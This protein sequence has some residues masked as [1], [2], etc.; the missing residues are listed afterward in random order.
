MY[1]S[2]MK[3]IILSIVCA[4]FYNLLCAQDASLDQIIKQVTGTFRDSLSKYDY[5]QKIILPDEDGKNCVLFNISKSTSFSRVNMLLDPKAKDE[6]L[7]I[8]PKPFKQAATADGFEELTMPQ[9]GFTSIMRQNIEEN[10]SHNG[11]TVIYK[12]KA[13]RNS[14]GHYGLFMRPGNYNLF[15]YAWIFPE[16][17]KP[18]SYSSNRKGHWLTKNNMINFVADTGQNDFLFDIRYVKAFNIPSTLEGRRIDFI[19]TLTIHSDTIQVLLNDPEVEDG[20]IISLNVNG[21]WKLRN[22]YLTNAPAKFTFVMLRGEN[23]IAMHAENLGSIPPNTGQLTIIDG[24]TKKQIILNSDAGKT[25]GI[26][27][28]RE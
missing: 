26:L 22:F 8:F 5:V 15:S 13:T 21:E 11:D 10:L 28:K 3:K 20:D 7:Y 18:V 12:T 1:I 19:Q 27:L 17:L 25:Q 4:A 6:M 16:G 2:Y 14:D 24:T 23:Y 9:G